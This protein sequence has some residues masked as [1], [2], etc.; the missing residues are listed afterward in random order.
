MMIRVKKPTVD[1]ANN[2]GQVNQTSQNDSSNRP[3]NNNKQ[4]IRVGSFIQ[5]PVTNFKPTKPSSKRK[6]KQNDTQIRSNS[7]IQQHRSSVDQSSSAS[8]QSSKSQSTVTNK[9]S[10]QASKQTINRSNNIQSVNLTDEDRE[11]KLNEFVDKIKSVFNQK[12]IELKYKK[13]II[14]EQIEKEICSTVPCFE[15][16]VQDQLDLDLRRRKFFS[17][18]DEDDYLIGHLANVSS[19]KTKSDTKKACFNLICFDGGKRR[20]IHDLGVCAYYLLDDNPVVDD[21]CSKNENRY[22]RFRVHKIIREQIFVTFAH[23]ASAHDNLYLNLGLI[24]L[25]ELP[26]HFRKVIYLKKQ[27]VNQLPDQ[28]AGS[29]Y[30]FDTLLHSNKQF[31]NPISVDYLLETLQI[32]NEEN[33]FKSKQFIESTDQVAKRKLN[34]DLRSGINCLK[35][36]DYEKAELFLNKVIKLEPNNT[37]AHVAIGEF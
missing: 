7:T 3:D 34:E 6:L 4:P 26:E 35:Q 5:L 1:G 24:G 18:V 30:S 27:Q 21:L 11:K 32:D 23:S 14:N 22:F 29:I 33:F 13:Q 17:Y 31:R 8:Q 10:A 28:R 36:Q 25:E 20:L 37:D 16:F 2:N 15:W 19:S 12:L 9:S